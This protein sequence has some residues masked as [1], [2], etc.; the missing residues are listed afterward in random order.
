MEGRRKKAGSQAARQPGREERKQARQ[1]GGRQVGKEGG[2][3]RDWDVYI[4][5]REE[6]RNKKAKK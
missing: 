6:G 4:Q 3:E 2:R 5:E 1:G